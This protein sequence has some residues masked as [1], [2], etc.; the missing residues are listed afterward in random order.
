MEGWKEGRWKME[1]EEEKLFRF[2]L[3]GKHTEDIKTIEMKSR[4]FVP[5]VQKMK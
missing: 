2:W 3:D 4:R 5:K 1:V